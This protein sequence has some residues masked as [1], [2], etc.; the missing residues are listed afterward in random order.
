MTPRMWRY[1]VLGVGFYLIFL[2]ITFPASWVEWGLFRYTQGMVSINGASGSLWRG[3]APLV[4]QLPQS[5]PQYLGDLSW[6]VNPLWLIIGRLQVHLNITAPNLQMQGNV[7]LSPSTIRVAQMHGK[8]P[9]SLINLYYAP[10]ALFAPSG[11]LHVDIDTLAIAQGI[12]GSIDILWQDAGSSLSQVNPLGDYRLH[13][14]GEGD[15]TRIQVETLRGVLMLNGQGHWQWGTG[16]LQVN[17]TAKP[18]AN[19]AAQ[20]EPILKLLGPDQG[21]GQR[22]WAIN[23]RL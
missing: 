15:T 17:G 12:N 19:S 10:A 8:L 1:T 20:V 16:Q 6:N 7:A 2:V 23:T 9:A 4:V 11:W 14:T 5:S 22:A 13:L 18:D 3:T 21:G